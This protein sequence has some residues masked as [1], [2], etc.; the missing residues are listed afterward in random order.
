MRVTPYRFPRPKQAARLALPTFEKAP[1][2]Y[3]AAFDRL[4]NLKPG[5]AYIIGG[6][7]YP[8]V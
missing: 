7:R 8:N 4:N 1:P 6:V 2:S 3:I 5:V